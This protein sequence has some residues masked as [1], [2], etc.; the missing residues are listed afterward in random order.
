MEPEF[1]VYLDRLQGG[2]TEVID[3]TLSSTFIDVEER[4]LKFNDP[5][6]IKGKAYLANEHLVIHLEIEV[7]ASIPCAICNK[8]VRISIKVPEF[9][10]TEELNEIKGK[11][12][13]YADP[14]R[15]AILLDVPSFGECKGG[16]PERKELEKYKPSEGNNDSV[17]FPFADLN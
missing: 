14:L 17:Q 11:I 1:K 13:Y 2:K 16:C 5:V 15:E 4:D 10:H 6:T 9:Y 12:Y 7:I 3:L 8:A